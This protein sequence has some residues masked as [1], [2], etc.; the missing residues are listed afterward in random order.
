MKYLLELNQFGEIFDKENN[1]DEIIKKL[2]SSGYI[3]KSTKYKLEE[4]IGVKGIVEEI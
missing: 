2:K 3:S 1:I 4:T